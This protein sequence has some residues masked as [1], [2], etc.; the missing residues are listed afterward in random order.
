MSDDI[1]S[2]LPSGEPNWLGPMLLLCLSVQPPPKF[3]GDAVRTVEAEM[4]LEGMRREALRKL[5]EMLGDHGRAE[6]DEVLVTI[7][8]MV[9]E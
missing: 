9:P 5:R 4:Q 1:S 3:R 2:D 8:L 7:G 6:L